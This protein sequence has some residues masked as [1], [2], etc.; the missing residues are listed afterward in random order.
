M[1]DDPPFLA[2]EYDAENNEWFC[3]GSLLGRVAVRT[4]TL[5]ELEEF[6]DALALNPVDPDLDDDL[7]A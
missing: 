5:W 4:K 2:V 7:P 3:H 6:L 1:P